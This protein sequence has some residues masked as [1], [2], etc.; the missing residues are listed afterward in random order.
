MIARQSYICIFA[1]ACTVNQAT[2][3]FHAVFG[4]GSGGVIAA[5]P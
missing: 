3:V 5:E 1:T 2:G 4:C